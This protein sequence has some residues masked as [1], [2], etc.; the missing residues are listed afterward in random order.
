MSRE[1]AAAYVPLST[2]SAR[3]G[4]EP[5]PNEVFVIATLLSVPS[6]RNC[7][8]S[9]VLVLPLLAM[10]VATFA[11]VVIAPA[12]TQ[13]KFPKSGLPE[14]PFAIRRSALGSNRR[15]FGKSTSGPAP[16]F[17]LASDAGEAAENVSLYR[18]RA[19][20]DGDPA[21]HD[22]AAV[23]DLFGI[24]E[25]ARRRRRAALER[26]AQ[27]LVEAEAVAGGVGVRRRRG[28]VD[29][30]RGARVRRRE[31]VALRGLVHLDGHVAAGPGDRV[32]GAAVVVGMAVDARTDDP[33]SMTVFPARSV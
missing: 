2:N 18:A 25:E 15:S 31:R 28:D 29:R 24:G 4:V 11:P 6:A 20:T 22:A 12:G 16:G 26:V 1:G 23:D 14:P 3:S 27:R 9:N 32:A 13:A 5:L 19:S 17:V 8:S 21:G 10:T 33:A 7:G 30:R